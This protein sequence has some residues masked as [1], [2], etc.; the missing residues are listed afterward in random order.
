MSFIALQ[1]IQGA[2]FFLLRDI[3]NTGYGGA[4]WSDRAAGMISS[5]DILTDQLS[6]A[7]AV[8]LLQFFY[9]YLSFSNIGYPHGSQINR[10]IDIN[11]ASRLLT[12]L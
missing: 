3:I 12:S 7:L 9:W 2:D 11:K 5:I 1:V 10:S 4:N 8:I 6:I